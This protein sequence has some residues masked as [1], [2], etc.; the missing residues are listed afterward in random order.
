MDKELRKRLASGQCVSVN[1]QGGGGEID[2]LSDLGFSFL[3]EA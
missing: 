1:C 3:F 2:L